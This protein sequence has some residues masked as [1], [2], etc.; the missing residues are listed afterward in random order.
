MERIVSNMKKL[1]YRQLKY[2]ADVRNRNKRLM[3]ISERPEFAH[4]VQLSEDWLNAYEDN[5]ESDLMIIESLG[6][7]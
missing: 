5:S 7:K 2:K 1:N 6:V 3:R 4:N